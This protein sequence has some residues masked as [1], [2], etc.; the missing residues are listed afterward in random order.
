[1]LYRPTRNRTENTYPHAALWISGLLHISKEDIYRVRIPQNMPG[2]SNCHHAGSML[3]KMASTWMV[4][5]VFTIFF[6]CDLIFFW[7]SLRFSYVC[8]RASERESERAWVHECMRTCACAGARVRWTCGRANECACGGRAG[9]H[10]CVPST[11]SRM[12]S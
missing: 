2:P 9:M 5:A 3:N 10:V 7:R 12:F 4:R 8:V 1:M 11:S 6:V